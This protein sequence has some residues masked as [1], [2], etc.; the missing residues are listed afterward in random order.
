MDDTHATFPTVEVTRRTV[1]ETGTTAL[2]LSSLPRGALAGTDQVDPSATTIALRVN[3]HLHNLALDPRTTL[4]DALRE[5]L[6]LT[7]SKKGCDHG[8][9]GA[10]TVLVEGRRINSCLTL[11]VMHDGQSIATVEGLAFGEALH[12]MQTAL[13]EHDGFQC[14]YCTSGQICSAVGML[15]ESREGVPSYVTADLTHPAAELSDDE[16]RERMSGNIC[17]CAAY[18]NIVAAI[19]QAMGE[20]T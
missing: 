17:R 18:P 15:A 7:G 3:G 6:A 10:C 20:Q 1:I 11:A 2:L 13:V 5:H 12:P 9:C 16:I 8:Q 4:L 14:G 19:K